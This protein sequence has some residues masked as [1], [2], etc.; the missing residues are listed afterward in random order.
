M[1]EEKVALFS[2]RNVTWSGVGKV[3]RGYNIV[4]KK[5]SEQWIKRSHIRI[6]TPQEIA[7][8]FNK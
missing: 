3:H 8:E 6:V 7:E 2:T 1:S 4:T 5:Q